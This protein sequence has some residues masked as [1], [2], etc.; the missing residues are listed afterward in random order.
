LVGDPRVSVAVQ[1]RKITIYSQLFVDALRS[2]ISYDTRDRLKAGKLDLSEPFSLIG[3]HL[4]ELEAYGA[5]PQQAG[6][7]ATQ[8]AFALSECACEGDCTCDGEVEPGSGGF[9]QEEKRAHVRLIL[10]YVSPLLKDHIAAERSRHNQHSPAC[11]YRMLWYLFRP[12]DMVYSIRGR[13]KAGT[14]RG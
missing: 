1:F 4:E 12:G 9:S 6:T 3:H 8:E 2:V 13:C 5:P 10:Q 11:T 14:Y 7:A